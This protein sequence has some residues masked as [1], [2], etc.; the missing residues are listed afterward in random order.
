MTNKDSGVTITLTM[1]SEDWKKLENA[2]NEIIEVKLYKGAEASKSIQEQK[3]SD[4]VF[5][6]ITKIAETGV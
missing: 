6:E 5:V 2:G 1:S 4:M 3:K